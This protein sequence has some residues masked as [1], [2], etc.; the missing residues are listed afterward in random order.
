[1]NYISPVA[2]EMAWH[3]A[4]EKLLGIE[5]TPRCKYIRTIIAELA[6][7]SD[8]LLCVGAAALDLGGVHRV[9]VRLQPA[10]EDL[11]HLR[12]GVGP[13]VPPELHPRRRRDVRRQRRLWSQK[14]RDFVKTFPKTHADMD[15]LLNRNRIFVD[16]TK[17]IGVLTKEEAINYSCTGPIARASGVVR[18]L[19]KDEPYLAYRS[20]LVQGGLRQGRR[21]LR[22]LPGPHGRDAREPED[23]R[24]GDR[25]PPGRAGER[26]TSTSK[27]VASRTRRRRTAASKG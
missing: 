9:P 1:M 21:L 18:D 7:I 23:H 24:A 22:P 16:R 6:R 20:R 15:R 11:R 17:G 2:N 13:A 12:D 4:V 10:R 8:H 26:R 14:V 25:E 5:L 3:H 19:R 27:A